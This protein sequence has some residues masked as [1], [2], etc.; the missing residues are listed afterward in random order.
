[1]VSFSLYLLE[2]FALFGVAAA[3][4]QNPEPSH[5][6]SEKNVKKWFRPAT[7]RMKYEKNKYNA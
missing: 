4:K 6:V 1:M 5:E 3:S 7:E 2:Y